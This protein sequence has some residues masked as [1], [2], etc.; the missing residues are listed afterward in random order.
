MSDDD[1]TT[2]VRRIKF[3]TSPTQEVPPEWADRMLTWLRDTHSQ[4]FIAALAHGADASLE[5]AAPSRRRGK[6]AEQ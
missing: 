1:E 2:P 3:G 4:I 6:P 5:L